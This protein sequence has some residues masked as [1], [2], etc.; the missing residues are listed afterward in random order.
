MRSRS[1]M[2]KNLSPRVL[3]DNC[4]PPASGTLAL[5]ARGETA[6]RYGT[7]MLARTAALAA[8]GARGRGFR[9]ASDSAALA[10]KF[11][12]PASRSKD[13]GEKP[14]DIVVDIQGWPVEPRACPFELDISRLGAC[15]FLKTL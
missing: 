14:R 13:S 7:S 3:C 8:I 2:L 6:R 5:P 9:R 11:A 15:C 10:P 1:R 12:H 4:L